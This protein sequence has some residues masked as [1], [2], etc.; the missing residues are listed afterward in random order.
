MDMYQRARDM[1]LSLYKREDDP[2]AKVASQLQYLVRTLY[3][4]DNTW[5][6][7]HCNI[8]KVWWVWLWLGKILQW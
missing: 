7:V 6:T 2:L 5:P 4:T 1:D 3:H 8:V